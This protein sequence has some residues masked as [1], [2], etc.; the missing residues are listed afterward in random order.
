MLGGH[1]GIVGDAS[2]SEPQGAGGS[3]AHCGTQLL[4][5]EEGDGAGVRPAGCFT[6]LL[7]PRPH[8]LE[9]C[10]HPF[11]HPSYSQLGPQG[12]CRSVGRGATES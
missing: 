4:R 9:Q 7:L 2:R 5:P 10:W 6:L 12:V 11:L 8:W 1:P 3:A